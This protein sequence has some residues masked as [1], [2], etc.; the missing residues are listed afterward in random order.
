MAEYCYDTL[1]GHIDKLLKK[2]FMDLA[3]SVDKLA[4]IDVTKKEKLVPAH[5]KTLA[6][7]Q[8]KLSVM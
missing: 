1:H 5:M 4:W 3:A 2:T 7:Q 6:L 8:G